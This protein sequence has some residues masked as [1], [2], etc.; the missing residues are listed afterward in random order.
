MEAIEQLDK[1]LKYLDHD[2]QKRETFSQ[3][4][5]RVGFKINSKDLELLL[6]QLYDDGYVAKVPIKTDIGKETGNHT[7]NITFNGRF[8][9]KNTWFPWKE[10]P[11]RQTRGIS[12]LKTSCTIAKTSIMAMNAAAIVW[13]MYSANVIAEHNSILREELSDKT[14]TIN[15]LQTEVS[16]L[17]ADTTLK[18]KTTANT[19]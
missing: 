7:F 16:V 13:L 6:E 2:L 14:L 1:V 11:Y 10:K 4:Q 3:I 5:E 17:K 18:E 8:I 19:H 9:L 12:R 15:Q